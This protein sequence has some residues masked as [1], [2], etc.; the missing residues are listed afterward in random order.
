MAQL[1]TTLH[2]SASND[3]Q[4]L[5][6]PVPFPY[7]P[8][9]PPRRRWIGYLLE[10]CSSSGARCCGGFPQS[11]HFGAP[12]VASYFLFAVSQ[13]FSARHPLGAQFFYGGS[14]LWGSLLRFSPLRF[15][16]SP[17][18]ANVFTA[19]VWLGLSII[20]SRGGRRSHCEWF[21]VE[22]GKGAA[23]ERGKYG[24]R[25]IFLCGGS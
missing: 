15:T 7:F 5:S 4:R 25:T 18:Y 23:L 17:S 2:G 13:S 9:L 6:S 20:R 14:G 19:S 16:G 24:F 21:D 8:V 10:P 3:S 11:P 12:M 1:V 22:R